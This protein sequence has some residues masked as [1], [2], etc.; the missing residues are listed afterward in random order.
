MALLVQVALSVPRAA[1]S[2]APPATA[3]AED[4]PAAAIYLAVLFLPVALAASIWPNLVIAAMIV[5]AD[6]ARVCE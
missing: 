1:R 5:P 4:P 2:G 3:V 6:S